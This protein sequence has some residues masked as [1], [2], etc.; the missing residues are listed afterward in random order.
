MAMFSSLV[1]AATLTVLLEQ[2]VIFVYP[3][4]VA[5]SDGQP[6]RH[7]STLRGVVK[8]ELASKRRVKA[9]R[10]DLKG[11]CE[12]QGTCSA[13]RIGLPLSWPRRCR[14]E[15][16]RRNHDHDRE[17]AGHS[18]CG[19]GAR[20][21]RAYVGG[22]SQ[23][24]R[25][26]ALMPRVRFAFDFNVAA[27]TA[28]SFPTRFSHTRH[29]SIRHSIKFR[30]NIDM[31]E[32]LQSPQHLTLPPGCLRAVRASRPGS[33]LLRSGTSPEKSQTHLIWHM[34]I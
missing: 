10:V 31:S 26:D 29:T 24:P 1:G 6:P 20:S 18:A 17:A 30:L 9:L 16:S 14:T 13:L 5:P 34:S 32:L 25:S 11:V 23:P 21:R 7:E 3:H 22:G 2:R 8:L 15:V 27:S 4:L 28:C 12:P 19:R 33:G